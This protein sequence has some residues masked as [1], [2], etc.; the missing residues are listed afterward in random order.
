[1][2]G[3]FCHKVRDILKRHDRAEDYVE[4]GLGLRTIEVTR[5]TILIYYARLTVIKAQAQLEK[6]SDDAQPETAER[7]DVKH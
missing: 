3:D 2:K 5:S 4:I 7:I 1:V 6:G